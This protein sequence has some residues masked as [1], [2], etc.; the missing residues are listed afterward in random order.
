MPKRTWHAVYRMSNRTLPHVWCPNGKTPF[1]FSPEVRG[2]FFKHLDEDTMSEIS[3]MQV[4]CR[5]IPDM[6]QVREE[7]TECILYAQCFVSTKRMKS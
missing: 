2:L 3:E 5:S 7:I 1:D 4:R 6:D